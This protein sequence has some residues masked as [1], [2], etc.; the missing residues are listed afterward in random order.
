M[1]GGDERRLDLLITDV[2][3]L[4]LSRGTRQGSRGLRI[5]VRLNRV[6]SV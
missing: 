4:A 2:E 3:G 1:V 5:V 6:V